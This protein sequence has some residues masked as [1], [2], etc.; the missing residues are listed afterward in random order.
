MLQKIDHI[1]IA[2]R[3]LEKSLKFYSR[4]LGLDVEKR[5]I[6]QGQLV[7]AACL[8]IGES[9]I[10]LLQA[11]DEDSPIA[12]F[13]EKRGEGIHHIAFRVNNLDE[14]IEQVKKSE[15]KLVD[16]KPRPG[17]GG[18]RMVFIHP[19]SSNGVLIELYERKYQPKDEERTVKL[20]PFE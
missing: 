5:E 12:K 3:D 4:V 2:V 17:V 8:G 13:I 19:K 20:F 11:I 18:A 7:H 1:G 6:V 10:E 15:Y 14:A 16:D 9:E